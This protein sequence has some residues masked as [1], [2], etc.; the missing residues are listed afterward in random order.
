MN[1]LISSITMQ[2][3]PT[4]SSDGQVNGEIRA[5]TPQLSNIKVGDSILLKFLM[6]SDGGMVVTLPTK[7]APVAQLLTDNLTTKN[8]AEESRQVDVALDKNLNLKQ[9]QAHEVVAK[10]TGKTQ[11]SVQVKLLSINNQPVEKFVSNTPLKQTTS[12]PQQ[13]ANTATLAQS[14]NV[15]LPSQ[16]LKPNL[17][18]FNKLEQ[19][20]VP[21]EALN[22]LK[23]SEFSFNLLADSKAGTNVLT[24]QN[25]TDI[26]KNYPAEKFVEA[27][28]GQL[29]KGEVTNLPDKPLTIKTALGEVFID[30]DIKLPNKAEVL[31]ELKELLP[32]PKERTGTIFD[33]IKPL[34]ASKADASSAKAN[35]AQLTPQQ[36]HSSVL[37]KIPSTDAKMVSNIISFIKAAV[38]KDVSLW[39]GKETTR[40]IALQSADGREV[41]A[42][43]SNFIISSTKESNFFWKVVEIPFLA[44]EVLSNIKFS[45]KENFD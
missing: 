32:F 24:P 21:K 42:K 5:S 2:I 45:I 15:E 3:K 27:L 7:T 33:I 38:N 41:V 36:L 30:K 35:T 29:I 39:L 22:T 31:L 4:A 28:K 43:L 19:I 44:G 11:D 16:Y 17:D 12:Q 14:K 9:G 8:P 18:A 40:E 10:I 37:S 23:N 6:E 20:N 26:I 25:L 13:P 34:L 1:D